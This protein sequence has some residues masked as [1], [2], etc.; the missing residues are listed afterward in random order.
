MAYG[1]KI[2]RIYEAPDSGDGKRVLVDRIWPRGVTK[3][4]AQ[5][6]DWMKA[7]APSGELCKWFGHKP[8]RFE[9]FSRR[10]EAE[11][12]G[13]TAADNVEWLLAR[14]GEGPVTLLYAARDEEHNQAV[15]LKRFLE[16]AKE[17]KRDNGRD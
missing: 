10:Y 15:V 1:F 13:G 12:A 14:A 17:S 3:E 11:L 7:I 4:K 2:K 16:A 8:D 5:L 6:D 9:E